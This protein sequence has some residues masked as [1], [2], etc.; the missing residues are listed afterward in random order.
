MIGIA[1]GQ[2]MTLAQI[3]K[4][5]RST[6]LRVHMDASGF[7][8]ILLALLVMFMVRA[9]YETHSAVAV[10]LPG[11][12]SAIRMGGAAREDALIISTERDGKIF[13]RTARILPEDVTSQVKDALAKGAEKKV[14][15]KADSR[16][17]YRA[18]AKVLDSVRA[19]GVESIGFLTAPARH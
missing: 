7:V 16:A 13:L 9:V 19:A 15:I 6:R 17:P 18:V 2:A 14:Y 11:S 1:I 3:Q 5:S 12:V 8:S 10:E 4:R